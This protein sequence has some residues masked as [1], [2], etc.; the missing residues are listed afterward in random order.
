MNDI[1]IT[2]RDEF[3]A[4]IDE[5]ATID[6]IFAA[7]PKVEQQ[8]IEGIQ[9][10]LEVLD[11]ENYYN[12]EVLVTAVNP[13]E[14][15]KT[16]QITVECF[17][18]DINSQGFSDNKT[19]MIYEP[20]DGTIQE[21]FI[22]KGGNLKLSGEI[23]CLSTTRQGVSKLAD[24]ILMGLT[25]DIKRFLR[26]QKIFISQNAVKIP[27]RITKVPL[28]KGT[29]L[30]EIIISI[31]EIITPYQQILTTKGEILRN[32]SYL[33]GVEEFELDE[34]ITPAKPVVPIAPSDLVL[35]VISSTQI[36]LSWTDN[37]DDETLFSIERSTDGVSYT[38][39]DTVE[40]D[41]T[42]YEDTGLDA[43]TEYFYRIRAYSLVGYSSYSNVANDTTESGTPAVISD[44]NTVAWYDYNESV[45]KDG[46]DLVSV[47]AD[48]LGSGHD[49]LQADSLK[50]PLWNANGI[51]FDGIDN[52]MKCVA[53]TYNQPA[54]IYMV[55]KQVTWVESG[56]QILGGN[57]D[58]T[59]FLQIG[60]SPRVTIYSGKF[61]NQTD[62]VLDTWGIVRILFN[63]ASSKY[64]INEVVAVTEDAGTNNLGGFVLGRAGSG[65]YLYTNIQVKEIILR[66][67]ADSE[68]NETAIYNYLK[69]KYGL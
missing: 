31:A 56:S 44:G 4:V 32:I 25:A 34:K 54:M 35:A 6:F 62:Y 60:A 26:Q 46:G 42:T 53:F 50:R 17:S 5:F 19:D 33:I 68:E 13:K 21:E 41:V 55:F 63:G 48:K 9:V 15:A 10:W 61:I 69:N 27:Q 57:T 3:K 7:L 52:S 29:S 28:N 8:I 49:L 39:I 40:A 22:I 12:Q 14:T 66:K 43:G 1:V 18:E 23:K 64:Q 45:T 30:W 11:E 58:A 51:L 24:A 2:S 20:T 67:V 16:H 38:E 59:R 36:D 65:E 37:S 47:W